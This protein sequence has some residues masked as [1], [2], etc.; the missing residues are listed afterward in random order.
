ML[1]VED[2]ATIAESI[3]ARLRAEGFTVDLAHDGPSG[4][5]TDAEREPDLVVLD[6]M[7]PGFDGLEVCRRIQ[8]RRPVPVLMLTARSDETDMLIG[9]GVGA[10]DYLTKP[11]SMRVL[12]ARV[13]ALLRRV[14]RA[15]R[16]DV[17]DAGTK[18]VLGDLEID[19]D[20]RRV[21]RAGN[22][23]Q[24][25]PIEF[26]LLVHFAKRPRAVQPRERL[27]SEVW[28]WDVAGTGS[29]TRA[30]DSHIKALRRKLGADLIRTVH[31]VGYALEVGS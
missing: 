14:E 21:T 22:Q 25:T 17:S 10:D 20:Q 19:V 8:A 6:V 13:H 31:G 28:D 18:I 9:L 23:A 11:F 26:D 7:L 29:G 1:V 27:L 2:D 12:S 5:E 3:A 15:A 4:V 16:T 24:L 30:V